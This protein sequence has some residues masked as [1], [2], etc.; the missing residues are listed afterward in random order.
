MGEPSDSSDD[1]IKLTNFQLYSCGNPHRQNSSCSVSWNCAGTTLASASSNQVYLWR[2]PSSF[3]TTTSTINSFLNFEHRAA[4]DRVRF[5]PSDPNLFCSSVRDRTIQLW[6]LRVDKQKPFGKIDLKSNLG[7]CAHSCEWFGAHKWNNSNGDNKNNSESDPQSMYLVISER[8]DSVYIYDVRKI[9][10]TNQRSHRGA[11]PRSSQ[12]GSDSSSGQV[13]IHS[14]DASP[15]A[16][17]HTCFS[18]SGSHLISSVTN[19]Q[20]ATSSLVVYPWKNSDQT[21]KIEDMIKSPSIPSASYLAHIGKCF[22]VRFSPDGQRMATG[23]ADALVGLWDVRSMVC[24]STITRQSKFIRGVSFSYDSKLLACCT[25]ED[26]V[27]ISNA[28]TGEHVGTVD[29]SRSGSGSKGAANR[30][31]ADEV[32]FHPKSYLLACAREND[33]RPNSAGGAQIPMV[34]IAK[35]T[36]K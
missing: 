31:G 35:L 20:D 24:T 32:S 29:L 22:A 10:Q 5:H 15:C 25:E 8:D 16:L 33:P 36:C 21:Q 9:Q 18:P 12:V 28:V 30:R 23:G 11:Y 17:R 27:D 14:F 13:P 34:T 2:S 26:L 7:S 3:D 6:D 19:K 1:N 4:V